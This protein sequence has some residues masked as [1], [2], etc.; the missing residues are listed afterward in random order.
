MSKVE[1]H[2]MSE[3]HL[4]GTGAAAASPF[5]TTLHVPIPQSGQIKR[6]A[7]VINT[8]L[9]GGPATITFELNGV[10]LLSGGV[11]ATMVVTSAMAAGTTLQTVFDPNSSV[12]Y[13]REATDN[14][15]GLTNG[16]VLALVGDG[17]GSAAEVLWV[18]TIGR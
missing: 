13:A 17:G 3:T 5:A 12:N 6:F 2:D 9:T 16:S 7:L 11:T 4:T 10:E 1:Q 14:E 18:L 15:N 8:A